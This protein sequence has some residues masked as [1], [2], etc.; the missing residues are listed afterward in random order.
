MNQT[1]THSDLI[2]DVGMHKGEDTD[3]YL[4]KG[5]RVVAFEANPELAHYCRQK[6]DA[7]ITA[8]KL[9]I[10]EGAILDGEFG[11]ADEVTFFTNCEVSEWGTVSSEWARRNE[12]LG[13]TNETITVKRAD[14][15]SC[16]ARFGIPFF[17]KID[18]EGMDVVCL[19][20]LLDF[21]KSPLCQDE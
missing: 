16:L 13:T 12:T 1:S 17:M 20:A 18:I 11:N 7:E 2:Y 5:F 14:F 6:F 8:Q 4:R 15:S 21:E 19:R 10:V 3:F 9:T